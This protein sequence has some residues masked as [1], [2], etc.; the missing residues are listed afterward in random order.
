MSPHSVNIAV[1][2]G[3]TLRAVNRSI[4][5]KKFQSLQLLLAAGEKEVLV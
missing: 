1:V 4:V 5:T 2:S 3:W